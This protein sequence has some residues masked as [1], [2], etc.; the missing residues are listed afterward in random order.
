[1]NSNNKRLNSL[2]A[3]IKQYENLMIEKGLKL[4]PKI[5]ESSDD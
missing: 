4:N 2:K 3:E 1:M 5:L